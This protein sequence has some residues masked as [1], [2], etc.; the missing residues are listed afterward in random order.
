[1]LNLNKV[2]VYDFKIT[3]SS[4]NSMSIYN[5][6]VLQSKAKDFPVSKGLII[7]E[8]KDKTDEKNNPS[9]NPYVMYTIHIIPSNLSLWIP[10]LFKF[11]LV[12]FK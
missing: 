3:P 4:I 5:I 7:I 1:L 9:K 8:N 6:L 2:A 10:C 12:F 11:L